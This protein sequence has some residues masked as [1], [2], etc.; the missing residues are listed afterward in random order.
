MKIELD[1]ANSEKQM[2]Q[3]NKKSLKTKIKQL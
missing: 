1:Q 3:N 2:Y